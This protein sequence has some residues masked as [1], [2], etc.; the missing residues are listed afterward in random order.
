MVHLSK[1][2]IL[3]LLVTLTF[4][5]PVRAQLANN[6]IVKVTY[7]SSPISQYKMTE[8]YM[9]STLTKASVNAFMKGITDYY[10]LYINLKNRSSVYV[11]DST[12][13]VRP[14]GW[15][16][17]KVTAALTDTVLFTLK[18]SDNHT[19]KHE[20][21]MNQTFFSEGRVDDIKWELINEEKTIDGLRCLKAISKEKYPMLTVWYT[22][23]LP[24]SN[25]PSVY[26]GLPGLV[27]WAE[28]YFRTIQLL[29]IE[30]TNNMDAFNKLYSAKYEAF[31]EEKKKGKHYDKEPL[32]LI[33]KGDLAKSYYDYFHAKP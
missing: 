23:E 9:R 10:S 21:I 20:W 28:D 1:Q 14:I 6:Q 3:F 29:K 33:K 15:E 18:S 26:Q 2:Y 22:K 31:A 7:T 24:V 4:Y 5:I 17:P 12:V 25:G 8:Y 16:S 30:Y 13:Q 11:L 19:Y 32:V 27:M